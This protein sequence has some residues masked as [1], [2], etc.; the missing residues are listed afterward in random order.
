[1]FGAAKLVQ[2]LRSVLF[3]RRGNLCATSGP[4]DLNVPHSGGFSA[5]EDCPSAFG[6]SG[7]FN[8]V[9]TDTGVSASG[10]MSWLLRS[11]PCAVEEPPL[12]P[13]SAHPSL[14]CPQKRSV[15]GQIYDTGKH[16]I[17]HERMQILG[18]QD[19]FMHQLADIVG[20]SGSMRSK[21]EDTDKLFRGLVRRALGSAWQMGRRLGMW[22][23]LEAVEY[24]HHNGLHTPIYACSGS[25]A[26]AHSVGGADAR[27]AAR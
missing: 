26:G 10:R 3:V 20:G 6:L 24:A 13:M 9:Q 1:M 21:L 19:R 14:P 11:I 17:V 25:G 7:M 16:R 23:V 12:P 5:D 18:G 27:R 2:S 15:G 4:C 8:C 22:L